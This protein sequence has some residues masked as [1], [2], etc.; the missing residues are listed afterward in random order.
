MAL[1]HR[2]HIF[3]NLNDTKG[4]QTV[5]SSMAAVC[6]KSVLVQR[7]LSLLGKCVKIVLSQCND[8]RLCTAVANLNHIQVP[9]PLGCGM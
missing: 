3:Q 1:D 5:L 7:A 6:Y 2:S 4:E 9:N 8:G